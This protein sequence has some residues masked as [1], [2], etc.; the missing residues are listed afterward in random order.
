MAEAPLELA[1]RTLSYAEGDAQVTVTHERSL[2]SRFARSSPTQATGVDDTTVEI[3]SLRDGHTAAA[4]TNRLDE[5]SLRAAA[6]RAETVAG[7]AAQGGPGDHPGL[8][9][10]V[11]AT[12]ALG[13]D[14]RTAQLDPAP[15]ADAL[16]SA[17]A[18]AA[19]AG[20]EAFGLW[21][22]GAVRTA[23][24]TSSGVRATDDLTDAFLKVVCRDADGRSGYAA[25]TARA[26]GD[27]DAEAL[28][29]RAISRAPRVD[30]IALA[31]G[32]YPVV[33]SADAVGV[34]LEFAAYLAFNGRAHVEGRGALSGRLGERIGALSIDLADVPAHPGGLPR[35]Y[36]AEGVPKQGVQLIRDGVA[37]AVVHDLRSAALAGDGARSTGH[38]IEPGSSFGPVPTNLVLAGGAAADEDALAAPVERGIYVTRLWYVNVVQDRQTLLTGMTRDGTFLI[39]DGKI[40]PPVRDVRFTDSVLRILEETEDLTAAQRLVSE[41]EFYGR[42]VANGVVCPALRAHGFR[43]TG[44]TQ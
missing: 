34:L 9:D 10:P 37:D 26:V 25:Q 36:D 13:W 18:G 8:P 40:G 17:F 11:P 23:I 1:E 6:R 30:G 4:T 19:A 15:A 42:R 21:T 44:A 31:P 28:V 33:L 29:R 3:V 41:G 38:A 16:R 39:E 43:V 24:A 12:P 22:A 32:E 20:L 35:A 7:V 2:S 5:A 27:L 14:E